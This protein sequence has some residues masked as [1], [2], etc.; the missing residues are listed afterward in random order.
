MRSMNLNI[1][2]LLMIK[3][4]F[5]IHFFLRLKIYSQIIYPKDYIPT[6]SSTILYYY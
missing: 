1:I 5:G 2:I 3:G 4:L 6:G